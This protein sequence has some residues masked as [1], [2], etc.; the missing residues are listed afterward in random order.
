[1]ITILVAYDETRVMGNNGGIPWR[2]SE[3]FKHFKRMTV[4]NPCIMG[5]KTWDS[6]P[7]KPL[8]DR[9]NI[10][11][12]NNSV[13][14]ESEWCYK[15]KCLKNTT[16]VFFEHT[17][18][19]AIDFASAAYPDKEIFIIGG[20]Q[21]YK[22]AMDK[23]LVDRVVASEI[24]GVHEGDTFFPNLPIEGMEIVKSYKIIQEFDDFKIVEYII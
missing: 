12:S 1:M 8:P 2:I 17:I 14:L 15:L 18:E 23:K 3:D 13:M 16:P 24:N 11:V 21:I 9:P 19:E 20:A 22:Q 4:G 6:L 5:R 10:V 7:K